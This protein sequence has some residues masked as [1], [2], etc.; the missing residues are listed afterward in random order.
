MAYVTSLDF[1]ASLLEELIA[2][3]VK[4]NFQ[5]YVTAVGGSGLGVL[6]PWHPQAPLETPPHTPEVGKEQLR[7]VFAMTPIPELTKLA[8]ERGRW[9]FV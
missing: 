8:E 4:D 9:L 1:A 7:S 2:D 6:S 3:L 5:P